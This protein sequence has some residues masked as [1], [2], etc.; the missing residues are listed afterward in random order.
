[1]IVT[2]SNQL[3]GSITLSRARAHCLSSFQALLVQL[4]LLDEDPWD[5]V[6][7]RNSLTLAP[8]VTL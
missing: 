6:L 8:D 3:D 2:S 4:V 5:S 1:M 7:H